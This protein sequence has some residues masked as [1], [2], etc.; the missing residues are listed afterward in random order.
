M[1]SEQRDL[2]ARRGQGHCRRRGRIPAHDRRRRG[3]CRAHRHL[4]RA[5]AGDALVRVEALAA[6]DVLGAELLRLLPRGAGWPGRRALDRA[7]AVRRQE[8]G[9][10]H[11]R[12]RA[13]VRQGSDEHGRPAAGLRPAQSAQ[14]PPARC[15]AQPQGR[16]PGDVGQGHR[17]EPRRHGPRADRAAADRP[18][19][20]RCAR[21]TEHRADRS[22]HRGRRR[23]RGVCPRHQRAR[24]V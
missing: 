11:A 16:H 17:Q 8:A 4:P 15:A 5:R 14:A 23:A 9:R 1:D 6:E 19:E 3:P 22:V 10:R 21:P 18:A 13:A 20:G 12:P 2:E 7:E 24:I